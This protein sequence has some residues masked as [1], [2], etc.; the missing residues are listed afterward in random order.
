MRL[1]MVDDSPE[2]ERHTTIL[3][4]KDNRMTGPHILLRVFKGE[5][6]WSILEGD[7]TC[8]RRHAIRARVC[9]FIAKACYP[10]GS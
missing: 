6:T 5:N 3:S 10:L 9:H 1:A 8:H 4:V 7:I 2:V